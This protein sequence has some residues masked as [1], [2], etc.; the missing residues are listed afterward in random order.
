[1]EKVYGLRLCQEC[2]GICHEDSWRTR[3]GQRRRY[4]CCESHLKRAQ[5]AKLQERFRSNGLLNWRELGWG[6]EWAAHRDTCW[7]RVEVKTA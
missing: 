2:G 6:G 1:M 5:T 7:E 3:S 4:W